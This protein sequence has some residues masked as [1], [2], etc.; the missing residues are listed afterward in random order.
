M[1]E[2]F[3]AAV[4]QALS[5][6]HSINTPL[7]RIGASVQGVFEGETETFDRSKHYVRLNVSP[8]ARIGEIAPNLSVEKVEASSPQPTPIT[9]K[10]I[11]SG[12]TNETLSPSGVGEISGSRLKLDLGDE[13]QGVFFIDS[14][15]TATKSAT[16]IRNK[17]SNLIFMIPAGLPTGEYRVEVRARLRSGSALKSGRLDY[18]LQVL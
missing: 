11:V 6:G 9:F 17:P 16:I 7:F 12:T 8:G 18:Q 10:D 3:E 14:D 1:L 2:E 15:G 4:E 5:D 13:E